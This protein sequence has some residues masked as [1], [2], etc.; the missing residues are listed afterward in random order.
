MFSNDWVKNW[1]RPA[2][3]LIALTGVLL[4]LSPLSAMAASN[5]PTVVVTATSTVTSTGLPS[6]QVN[7]AL[8]ACGNIYS[9]QQYGGAV[10]ETPYGGGTSTTV[11]AAGGANY[12]PANLWIDQAKANLYV[13]Q[14]TAGSVYKIPITNCV[15][16]TGSQTSISIGNLGAISYYWSASAVATDSAGDVFIATDIA[17]CA[18]ANELL[19]ENA[20][21]SAGTSLLTN[22][23]SPITGIAVDLN[24]NIYYVSNGA[25]YELA[26]TSGAYSA[27]PVSFGSG[28][29]TVVGVNVDAAG[30]L[31]VADSGNSEI[32]EVPNES[33]GSTSALNVS[34]QFVVVA[35]V[36]ITDAP[37][38][39]PSGNLFYAN[40][41]DASGGATIYELTRNNA[42]FGSLAVGSTGATTLNVLFD[43]TATPA[44]IGF[45]T[46]AGIFSAATGGSCV[47]GK[48]Y[49]AGNSCTINASFVPAVPGVASGAVVLA[50]STG[51]AI[52][53]I[54]LHGKG[55]GAGITID[56]GTAT[57]FASGYKTPTSVALDSAGDVFIADSASSTVWE[58]ASG[59]TTPIKIGGGLSAPTGVAVDGA[60][61]VYIADTGNSRIVEVPVISGVL[62]TTGQ[63]VLVASGTSIAGS[64]L[65]SPAGVG[66][67]ATGNLYIADTGNNR[68]LF[69]PQSSG[70][71]VDAASTLGSGFSG[72]LATAVSATGAIYI[73]DSGNGKIF[74]IPYPSP[75]AP[76][77]LV[78]TGYD[79]PSSLAVDP[80]G[81]LF[82]VEKGS[83]EVLRIPETSG[84][85][86]PASAINITDGIAAPYGVAL[87]PTGNLYITDDVNAAAYWVSRTNADVSFGDTTPGTTG[88][89][90]IVF[91]ENSGN[92]VL[93]TAYTATGDTTVFPLITSKSGACVSG[94][95]IAVG[96]D[97][98]LEAEFAPTAFQAYSETI[99]F[100]GNAMNTTAPQVVFTGTGETTLPTTATF[101]IAAPTGS[102]YYGEALQISATVT[103]TTGTP[104]GAVALLVDGF[105][106]TTAT[107]NS[108]GTATLSL[109]TGLT[110]GSHTLQVSYAGGQ[111][112]FIVY[113]ASQSATQTINVTKVPT[114]TALSILTLYLSPASQPA[115]SAVTLTATVSSTYTG[116]PTG[117]VTFV[118]QDPGGSVAPITA[119]LV[120]TGGGML[121]ATAS[122]TPYPPASGAYDVVTATATYSGDGNFLGSG[123]QA[124]SFDVTPVG[125]SIILGTTGT[126]ITS[127]ATSQ[128]SVTFTAIS[129]G[130]WQGVIGYQCLASTL[131]ANAICVFSP[132]QILLTAS[133]PAATY[134]PGTTQLKIVVNN[135]PNSPAQSSMLWWLAGLLSVGL[136]V[137]RRRLIR[138]GAWGAMVLL[139][140]VA[141]SFTALSAM[142]GCS[143]GVSF[144]TP[145]GTS[146]VT[147][148]ASSDPY[149]SGSTSTTQACGI[150]P[151]SNPPVASPSLAPC[152]QQT[153]QISLT[154]K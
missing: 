146:T 154:V 70:W 31:Y 96:S 5:V 101:T 82:V 65:S 54:N 83:S 15:P 94:A 60:G 115:G 63:I 47:A 121:Q 72:P 50:D 137:K 75:S 92:Q 109:P 24:N 152:A 143:N 18:S 44:T 123:S 49:D 89:P 133:T 77:A 71:N 27:T 25:L 100:S 74:T 3:G 142:S 51:A 118:I 64:A 23:N 140:A 134:P 141:A 111:A 45:A 117:S 7:V 43:A 132:G 67:D 8:D 35:G 79:D 62:S 95:S 80:A 107:L 34:D 153:F 58:A 88:N 48:T 55:L 56:P 122:Y 61:N 52:S 86:V 113:A 135:P 97:C 73:A 150:I 104:T 26:Y 93:T 81:N 36:S 98:L 29:S 126:S 32:F 147:V 1:T 9:M 28:Y 37:A 119:P 41:S 2:A 16:Q 112:G 85:L 40:T 38:I 69:L 130:G 21:D 116:V 4:S 12:T 39:D 78:A 108:S 57:P 99:A 110:A 10:T 6:D 136:L 46:K 17:C 33:A 87:D 76:L 102:P 129:Y 138:S 84:N 14:G 144:A 68:I 103:A 145:T 53:T 151:G 105:Q 149:T 90:V 148:V 125:G 91:V 128:T 11:L 114:A 30:N 127:S 20:A 22:L 66:L 131:P 42:N 139:I 124:S 106:V 19:E 59:S 13:T 120:V